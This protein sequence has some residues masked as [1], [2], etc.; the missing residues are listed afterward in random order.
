MEEE[1]F[2]VDAGLFPSPLACGIQVERLSYAYPSRQDYVLQDIS[3][4]VKTGQTVA[5]VGENGA[6]KTTL[7]KCLLGLYRSY[8]GEIRYDGLEV[9][10]ISPESMY[11]HMS[12]IFQDFGRY[13][14]TAKENIGFGRVE[15]MDNLGD[16]QAA[17]VASGV[18]EVI[19]RLADG[20]DTELGP[21]FEGG[22]ELSYG[23]WQKMALVRALFRDGDL[24]VLDEPTASMYPIAEAEVFEQFSQ[25][26]AGRTAILISH[27]LGSCK[28]ADHI[29][30][31]EAGRLIEQ[32]TH[33]ELIHLHGKYATM[34][35]TQAKWYQTEQTQN[36]S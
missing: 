17:A 21:M 33:D 15:R 29:L 12:A 31:L 6:G 1:S 9:R 27:R 16:L 7:V 32:G 18:E 34:F 26:A 13:Q 3:F 10:R 30:V 19:R 2:P 8:D 35:M 23:Q 36:I 5:I 25:L 24:I 14:M 22:Q 20:Y 28:H 11:Q 4:H